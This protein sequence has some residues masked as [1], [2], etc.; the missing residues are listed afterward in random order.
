MRQRRH[1]LIVLILGIAGC[2]ATIDEQAARESLQ[3][4]TTQCIGKIRA[5][6]FDLIRAGTKA[7]NATSSLVAGIEGGKISADG[8]SVAGWTESGL[9]IA[10]PGRRAEPRHFHMDDI[11]L[12]LSRDGAVVAVVVREQMK[13]E[14]ELVAFNSDGTILRTLS[15][16]GHNPAVSPDG[17]QVAFEDRG[18]VVIAEVK[19][20]TTTELSG[21]KPSWSSDGQY[22]STFHLGEFVIVDV[23][24]RASRKIRVGGEPLTPLYWS[25]TGRAAMFVTRTNADLWSSLSCVEQYRVMVVDIPSANTFV[26]HVGCSSNPERLQWLPADV[27]GG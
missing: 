16:T 1:S 22:I 19:S 13:T 5:G 27:C 11:Q 9:V 18:H 21:T 25:T 20:D 14:R 12:D 6:G 7:G 8:K 23:K 3:A 26:Y 15:A 10:S 4:L 2:S 17:S 24:T